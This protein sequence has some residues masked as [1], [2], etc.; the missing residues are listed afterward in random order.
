MVKVYVNLRS[1][2]VKV[3]QFIVLLF[4]RLLGNPEHVSNCWLLFLSVL[5]CRHQLSFLLDG[6]GTLILC[7]W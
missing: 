4:F 1:T 6:D 7:L 3:C 5:Q 2:Y